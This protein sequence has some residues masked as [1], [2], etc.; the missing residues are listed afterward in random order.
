MD[1]KTQPK[2][3][4]EC[5]CMSLGRRNINGAH[6]RNTSTPEGK[7]W[8]GVLGDADR[9]YTHVEAF[10]LRRLGFNGAAQYRCLTFAHDFP[11]CDETFVHSE[12]DLI[13]IERKGAAVQYEGEKY[14]PPI[15]SKDMF[16]RK[17]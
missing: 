13:E 4:H 9:E 12:K 5:P 14:Q 3:K 2:V 8:A 10:T 1:D 6:Q 11:G 16:K 7:Y 17:G 15:G